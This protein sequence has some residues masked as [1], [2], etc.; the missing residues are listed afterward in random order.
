MVT[1]QEE[2]IT[3][4]IEEYKVLCAKHT[5]HI[6]GCGCCGSPFIQDGLDFHLWED[7]ENDI[8]PYEKSKKRCLESLEDCI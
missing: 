6:G 8:N 2:R 1:P 7:E 3:Q 5:I 4:F